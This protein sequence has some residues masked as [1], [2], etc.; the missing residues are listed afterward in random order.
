LVSVDE[1]S[2]VSPKVSEVIKSTFTIIPSG[3]DLKAYNTEFQKKHAEGA[4]AQQCALNVRFILDPSTKPQNEKDLQA[5]LD[6]P[7]VTREQALSGLELL[8]SWKSDEKTKDAY[9]AAASKKW[10]EATVFE[11]AEGKE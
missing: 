5:T 6:F 1:S 3:T 8:D 2:D 10:A 9:R 11:K 4:F 7:S